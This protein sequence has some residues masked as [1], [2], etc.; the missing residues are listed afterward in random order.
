M[1]QQ[2]QTTGMS[3][4]NFQETVLQL[5]MAQLMTAAQ[6]YLSGSSLLLQ[7]IPTRNLH[8]SSTVLLNPWELIT[9]LPRQ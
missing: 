3:R 1:L 2:L 8:L 6:E 7:D 4:Y 5:T 9:L